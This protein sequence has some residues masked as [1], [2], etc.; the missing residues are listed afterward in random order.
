[1]YSIVFEMRNNT[2]TNLPKKLI[3]TVKKNIYTFIIC[4]GGQVNTSIIDSIESS[5]IME[6]NI[7][8]NVESQRKINSSW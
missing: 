2:I 3:W 4:E 6:K 7:Q 1:M 8:L 5:W